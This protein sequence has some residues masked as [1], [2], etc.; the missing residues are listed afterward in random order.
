[1]VADFCRSC[2]DSIRTADADFQEKPFKRLERCSHK[3]KI[4]VQNLNTVVL[5]RLF[6]TKSLCKGYLSKVVETQ[7]PY[8]EI[9][10]AGM[11]LPIE[12]FAAELVGK[13]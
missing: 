7:E 10:S 8:A 12:V 11:G 5:H 13:L 1:M 9:V 4:S 6:L 3:Q 2:S